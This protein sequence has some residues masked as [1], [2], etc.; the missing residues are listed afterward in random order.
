[1]ITLIW[2][3][4]EHGWNDKLSRAA[5]QAALEGLRQHLGDVPCP[6]HGESPTIMIRGQ[7]EATMSLDVHGC[8]DPSTQP[9]R[10]LL[11]ERP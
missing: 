2:E 3:V 5:L 6:V 4:E 8:C 1:V 10:A 11:A 9:V 7:S